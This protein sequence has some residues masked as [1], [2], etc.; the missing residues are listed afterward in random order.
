MG[1]APRTKIAGLRDALALV[2]NVIPAELTV[3]YGR[4]WDIPAG[5]VELIHDSE[6][7]PWTWAR[8][9]SGRR[10]PPVRPAS[11]FLSRLVAELDAEVLARLDEYASEFMA[12][13]G[14]II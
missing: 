3:M 11:A 2:H 8:Y 6:G 10:T 4:D 13:F 7:H 5:P 1:R 9:V 12:D 14:L